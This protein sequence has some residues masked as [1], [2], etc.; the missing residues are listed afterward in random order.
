MASRL[1]SIAFLRNLLASHLAKGE[2]EE[3]VDVLESFLVE[4]TSLPDLDEWTEEN[5]VDRL[6]EAVRQEDLPLSSKEEFK[7]IL[8]G[9]LCEDWLLSQ[10]GLTAHLPGDESLLRVYREGKEVSCSEAGL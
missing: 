3:G 6:Q 7:V 2:K 10:K 9:T 1:T 5:M 4:S 8:E